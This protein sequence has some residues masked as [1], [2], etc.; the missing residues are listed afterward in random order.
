MSLDEIREGIDTIDAKLIPLLEKRFHLVSKLLP[1]KKQLTDS[2]RE[3]K[4]LSK[5]ESPSVRALYLEIF[6]LS[7]ELLKEKGFQ[8]QQK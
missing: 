3:G 2:K 8:A 4:I 6:R 7:K 1:L 5:T